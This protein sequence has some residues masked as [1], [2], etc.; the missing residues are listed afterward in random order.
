MTGAVFLLNHEEYAICSEMVRL[1]FGQCRRKDNHLLFPYDS[2]PAGLATSPRIEI[3]I[4]PAVDSAYLRTL[5]YKTAYA[6]EEIEPL[7]RIQIRVEA[8]RRYGASCRTSLV[9]LRRKLKMIL[10]HVLQ[11]WTGTSFPWGSLSG[12]RPTQ[13]CAELMAKYGEQR[14]HE[15]LLRDYRL[16]PDKARLGIEVAKREQAILSQYN[17][18]GFVVYCGLPFCPTRCSYCSFTTCDAM[19]YENLLPDYVEAV[20]KEAKTVFRRWRRGSAAA[21]YFGGGTPT[22]LPTG[23]FE[24]YIKGL[25]G[26]IPHDSASELT[27]EAGRPDTLDRRKLELIKEHGFTRL[28]IN[29]QTMHD[30]SLQ[31]IGRRHTVAETLKA[32][33]SARD[34]GFKSINMDLIF[35]LPDEP[36]SAFVTSLEQ[37]LALAPESITLHS[38]ALKHSSRLLAEFQAEGVLSDIQPDPE[39]AAGL[40]RAYGIL[41]AA[42]YLPY[43]LYKQ[44]RSRGALENTGFALPGHESAYN[45]L[46][47]SDRRTVIGLG[48]GSTSKFCDG[49]NIIRQHNSKD[50]GDYI[51]RA[52][53][54]ACR[55]VALFLQ[56]N[57]DR[58]S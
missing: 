45:V 6:P 13:I 3:M 24:R 53:E 16:L 31:R 58:D 29:P 17:T 36:V 27:M 51:S 21:V 54:F 49:T 35:G 15:I 57:S 50:L 18:D 28:C 5:R 33:H 47:M 14:A 34:F 52:D 1:F 56:A 12:V 46:M 8:E 22:C 39:L 42:G 32:Y 20:I 11:E 44:K 30:A 55:K 10:Y 37:V 19:R 25:L 4:D 23:L 2:T 48:S 40:E 26:Y 38:L 7:T 41:R 9:E 43:Y